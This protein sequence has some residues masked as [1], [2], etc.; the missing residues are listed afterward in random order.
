M[1]RLPPSESRREYMKRIRSAHTR[2]LTTWREVSFV[3]LAGAITIISTPESIILNNWLQSGMFGCFVLALYF[4]FAL[5]LFH[6]A[7]SPQKSISFSTF[8]VSFNFSLIFFAGIMVNHDVGIFEFCVFFG[9]LLSILVG[10]FYIKRRVPQKKVHISAISSIVWGVTL[11][12][13]ICYF[14]FPDAN[15]TSDPKVSFMISMLLVA[16]FVS[17]T[18][19]YD[20]PIKKN[21]P[22]YYKSNVRAAIRLDNQCKRTYRSI[23]CYFLFNALLIL[24]IIMYLYQI[25]EFS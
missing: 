17:I 9:A 11:A 6:V 18:F 5:K 1:R 4:P 15:S 12:S 14:C 8:G 23:C 10:L 20:P 19:S 21:T 25:K 24:S 3:T 16:L 13:V 7:A 2:L 22:S